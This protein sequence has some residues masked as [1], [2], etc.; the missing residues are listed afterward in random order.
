MFFSDT[1]S[2]VKIGRK[3]IEDVYHFEESPML[4]CNQ[5]IINNK[6]TGVSAF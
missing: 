5:F 1:E 4:D 3:V 6:G 2:S